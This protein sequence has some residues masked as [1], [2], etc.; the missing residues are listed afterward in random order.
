LR[1]EGASL[2]GLLSRRYLVN[3]SMSH[4]PESRPHSP[5]LKSKLRVRFWGVRGSIPTP[6]ARTTRF[7]GN[8]S[9]I[10]ILG[11]SECVI[12]DAGT[13]IRSL[14]AHL[15][16]RARPLRAH[17]L[18]SHTH[19]DHIQ[20]FPLFAPIYEEG[21]EVFVY[22]P[23]ALDKSLHDAVMFQMQYS[24]FPVRGVELKAKL[25]FRELDEEKFSISDIDLETRSMNHPI[26]VLAYRFARAGKVGVYTG[27]NEPYY[28]VLPSRP[29]RVETG[30]HR[31]SEFIQECNDR[32]TQFVK[33][34]DLLIADSQYTDEEYRT[35]K[36]WG[37]SSTGQ[38]LQ[39][40]LDAG[41][42]RIA[43]F[44]H[45]PT[46]ADAEMAAI[47]R[48]AVRRARA[49]NP[50]LQVLTAREGMTVTV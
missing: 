16:G 8:T 27:D 10:E 37:H 15:A 9:C 50:K 49:M 12:L 22:G 40:A 3:S 2:T 38:A 47:H 1:S 7:G 21:N 46:H 25:V 4:S 48:D 29:F 11:S 6:G 36:G 35:K 41:A 23:R 26:R 30:I 33:G 31:R 43:L 32:V 18:L 34:C 45:E 20:G 19:W 44:H 24:Y 28:D 14:G 13:G 5:G 42:K 17:I 39:L